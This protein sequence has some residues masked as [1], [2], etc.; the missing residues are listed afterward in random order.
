MKI[1]QTMLSTALYTSSILG[2]QILL[3]DK[4]LWNAAPTH[5]YVLIIFVIVDSA[6][7]AAMWRK[8]MLATIG[9][10]LAST[11]Q[12]TA[13][14]GDIAIGQPSGISASVFK[15]YLLADTAFI[16]LLA[17]QGIILVMATTVLTMPLAH[18]HGLIL[19]QVRK[20]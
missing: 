11:A 5:A 20:H 2:I 15:S 7:L 9:A 8:T 3:M 1:A 6:L 10:T 13:M 17:T 12:L 14:L 16:S 4:W 19:T 18:S